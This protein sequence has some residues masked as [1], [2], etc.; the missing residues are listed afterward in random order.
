VDEDEKMKYEIR[1]LDKVPVKSARGKGK[2]TVGIFV[3]DT[4]GMEHL[5]ARV[6]QRTD[7]TIVIQ[8]FGSKCTIGIRRDGFD[9]PVL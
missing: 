8:Y 4:D 7:R 2:C 1:D 5:I 3:R 9:L 6:R